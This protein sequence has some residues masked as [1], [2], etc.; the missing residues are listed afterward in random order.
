MPINI[1]PARQH[2]HHFNILFTTTGTKAQCKAR[3]VCKAL[4][5]ASLHSQPLVDHVC[6]MS[7]SAG[8]SSPTCLMAALQGF[9]AADLPPVELTSS[10]G[11]RSSLF[12]A[13]AARFFDLR[14]QVRGGPIHPS[15]QQPCQ[16]LTLMHSCYRDRITVGITASLGPACCAA[17][18]A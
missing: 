7:I 8:A 14:S 9:S 4:L 12:R 17:A 15:S 11:G 3:H 13:S 1:K 5:S 10:R 16:L 6:I 2:L 18:L